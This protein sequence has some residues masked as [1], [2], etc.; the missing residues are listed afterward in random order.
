MDPIADLAER[1]SFERGARQPRAE[2]HP[3]ACRARRPAGG[4][5]R[6]ERG[7]PRHGQRRP[8]HRHHR[9]PGPRLLRARQC[10]LD[11]DRP[12]HLGALRRATPARRRSA[13]SRSRSP[14]ASMPAAIT[15]SATSASSAS[16]R[17]ARSSTSSPSAARATRTASVGEIIGPGFSSDEIIDAVE[18]LVDTYL[19]R[20]RES[21]TRISSPPIADSGRPRS[22]RRS[23][24]PLDALALARRAGCK[25]LGRGGALNARYGQPRCARRDLARRRRAL[26]R[27]DR[28]GVELRRRVG[29][30]APHARGNR[31]ERPGHLPR[32][33]PPLRRDARLPDASSPSASA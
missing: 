29:G 11:P 31:P 1:Y 9:L 30:A 13:S 3:P 26:P 2:P 5:R 4:P 15:M 25:Q 20:A 33:R 32:Y 27:P 17:R 10:P 18:T 22:R 21:G 8:R 24:A 7:E 6:A 23:M 19:K 16:R 14:A 28:A 12:A